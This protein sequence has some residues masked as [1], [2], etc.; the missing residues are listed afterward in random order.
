MKPKLAFIILIWGSV[1]RAQSV[2]LNV[3]LNN[4]TTESFAVRDIQKMTFSGI[5]DITSENS[6][7][8]Q[9]IVKTFTLYQNYP[10]PFNP[11]TNIEYKL[12]KSGRVEINI[13]NINGQRLKQYQYEFQEAGVYKT[14]WNGKNERGESVSSGLYLYEV[15][16]EDSVFSKKMMLL[17]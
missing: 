16:F 3:N 5:T 13:F 11:S 1:I 9:N 2:Y 6:R 7:K 4:G 8:I 14:T 10:N 12:P 17:K 15:K